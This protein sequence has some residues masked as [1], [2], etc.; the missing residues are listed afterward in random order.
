MSVRA[1][2]VLSL[3][4]TLFGVFA[5]WA[6]SASAAEAQTLKAVKDRGSLIC[7]V[8]QG[9]GGFSVADPKGAW[10]GFDVD[11]CRAI[12]AAIFNDP[13]KVQFVEL[14][15]ADRFP[16]LASGKIDILA[17][18]STW[19]MGR[20]LEFGIVFTGVT[21]YD[22]QGFLV[23]KSAGI[24]S[25][26]ELDGAKVCVQAGT[27]S[28]ANVADF[29]SANGMKLETIVVSSPAEAA[30]AYQDGRCT[31]IS[32]DA[33]QLHAERRKLAKPGDSLVLPDIISKEP[34]GPAVRQDDMQWFGLVKWVNFAM[35]NAEELGVS[36]KTLDEALKSD[37]P[38]VKRLVGR[39][40]DFGPKLGLTAD[41]AT[42]IIR[43]VG[44][45][46]EVYDRNIGATS[47]LDIPRGVNQLWHMGGIQYAPPIR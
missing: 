47:A 12:A 29:F 3:C 20:E 26:V 10:T 14:S 42:R 2:P 46:G 28:Q 40:G 17:R 6:A 23:P 1:R 4:S 13:T 18:N 24:S 19:T 27:T 25:A 5:V 43:G 16:A 36:A 44:N 32:S 11:F 31:A 39:D 9:L 37:K 33:S 21:Y 7:G 41:W 35:L 45:Y 15:A 22:G 30:A 34:L 38:D 8:S